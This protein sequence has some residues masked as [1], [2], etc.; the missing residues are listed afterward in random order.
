MA[1]LH[2][3]PKKKNNAWLWILLLL[4]IAAA[5]VYYFAVYKKDHPNEHAYMPAPVVLIDKA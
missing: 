4:I 3:Q 5:A 1:N 2:V